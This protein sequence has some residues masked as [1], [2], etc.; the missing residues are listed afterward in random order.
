[1]SK[2]SGLKKIETEL[3]SL[4][5]VEQRRLMARISQHLRKKLLQKKPSRDWSRLYGLG[6][7]LWKRQDAQ[8]YINRLREDRA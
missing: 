5:L 1:M 6:K 8:S 7:G 3:K 4:S 2:S